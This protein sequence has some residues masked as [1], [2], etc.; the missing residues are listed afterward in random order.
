[1]LPLDYILLFIVFIKAVERVLNDAHS[2]L[3]ITLSE[4]QGLREQKMLLECLMKI[5]ASLN[6]LEKLLNVTMSETINS[7]LEEDPSKG[8][9]IGRAANEYNQ[10]QHLLV[11]CNNTPLMVSDLQK[12]KFISIRFGRIFIK[13]GFFLENSSSE[14]KFN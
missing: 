4:R 3:Q 5:P 12:V 9:V 14:H 1:M 13:I 7:M 11:K 10:L 2:K 8:N 6:N